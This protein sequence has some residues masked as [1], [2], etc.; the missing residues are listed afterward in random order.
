M[1]ERQC[2]E[3]SIGRVY[4]T[5]AAEFVRIT[6]VD[7]MIN[8]RGLDGQSFTCNFYGQCH[9]T[10]EMDLMEMVRSSNAD[11]LASVNSPASVKS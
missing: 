1:I 11:G 2:W 8:A 9:Q 7:V 10:S 4:M 6:S 3:A 5:R